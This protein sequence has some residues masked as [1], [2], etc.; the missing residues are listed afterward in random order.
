MSMRV[1]F[2]GDLQTPGLLTSA[3]PTVAEYNGLGV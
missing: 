3:A 1:T 2:H